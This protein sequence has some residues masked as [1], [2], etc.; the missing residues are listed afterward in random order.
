MIPEDLNEES[1]ILIEPTEEEKTNKKNFE[2]HKYNKGCLRNFCDVFGYNPLLWF[3]PISFK[4]LEKSG[5]NYDILKI[6]KDLKE[7]LKKNIDCLKERTFSLDLQ[8]D[9]IEKVNK[10]DW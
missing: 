7:K 3:L 6:E 5:Y 10:N 1:K 9:S 8:P 4:N 2:K